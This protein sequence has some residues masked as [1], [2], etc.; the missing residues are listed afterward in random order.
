[1]C[2]IA[3][4]IRFDG[5]SVQEKLIR[6][7]TDRMQLRGPDDSGIY[8]GGRVGLG[9]RRLSIID[10]AG[11]HQ[12]ISNE[13]GT[14]HIVLNG[15]I[16][17]YIELRRELESRG[18]RFKT[19]S[20]VEVVL[21]LYED[22]GTDAIQQLNGMFAFC[23]WDSRR[24]TAWIA[25]DRFGIKPLFY[26]RDRGALSFASSIDSLRELPE[27][28]SGL[29]EDGILRYLALSYVSTPYSVYRSV[30]KL[31]PASFLV[32]DSR[33]EIEL[34]KYW[35]VPEASGSSSS[36]KMEDY[37]LEAELLFKSST[38]LHSRS[39]VPVGCFLSGGIDSSLV[40]AFFAEE[41]QQPFHTFSVDFTGKQDSELPFARS[42]SERCRTIHHE[43]LLDASGAVRELRELI[44]HLDEP[45]A[46]SAIVPSYVLS[47]R[48]RD[49]DIKVLLSGAGGDEL[50]GG[51]FR[52]YWH[53]RDRLIG[54]TSALPPEAIAHPMLTRILGDRAA[55]Y[56]AR[57]WSRGASFALETSGI[58]PELL[59]RVIRKPARVS[60]MM[61]LLR[62]EF[63][64]VGTPRGPRDALLHYHRM[65]ADLEHYLNDNILALFDKTSM[66]ASVEGRVPF[67]DHRLVE[68][69]F[70]NAR[71]PFI[72]PENPKKM[73]RLLGRN[74]VPEAILARKKVGF[75]GP[76][77]EW[78]KIL[79]LGSETWPKLHEITA[80]W[81]RPERIRALEGNPSAADLLFNLYVLDQW[82]HSHERIS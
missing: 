41:T 18:H 71:Y 59:S 79:H 66:A 35:S 14:I 3:G 32:V 67:L 13:D 38:E 36:I 65:K 78:L 53:A 54:A 74:R 25:R 56:L 24:N 46:D 28:D 34:K 27:F 33:G 55:G 29:D 48:A 10:L 22:H 69:A 80:E 40:S 58:R 20:D 7:M 11:G 61:T 73:L 62:E 51:Y 49:L 82:L 12:P 2:G 44:P 42:V 16:Y 63:K 45:V 21:H 70:K 50:F 57:S 30:R 60:R 75:N 17:N 68:F 4:Q 26:T 77:S 81:F 76:I 43:D 23:L 52:H 8:C 31:P 1:M 72:D 47:K 39:D 15:E 9:M 64:D 5:V 37:L 19:H 6:G